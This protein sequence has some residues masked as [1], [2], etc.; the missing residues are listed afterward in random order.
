MNLIVFEPVI[1]KHMLQDLKSLAT[2]FSEYEGVTTLAKL[3]ISSKVQLL[4]IDVES[5]S[6][7][8]ES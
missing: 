5:G 8:K 6:V 3:F 2:S 7:R 4:L 1:S